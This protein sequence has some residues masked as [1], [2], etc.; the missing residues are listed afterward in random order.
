MSDFI[1]EKDSEPAREPDYFAAKKSLALVPKLKSKIEEWSQFIS[2]DRPIPEMWRRNLYYYFGNVV[3]DVDESG[4][5]RG[6][7]NGEFVKIL[8]NQARSLVRQFMTLTSKARLSFEAVAENTESGTLSDTRLANSLCAHLVKKNKIDLLAERMFE[9]AILF[10]AGYIAARWNPA[11]GPKIAATE[12]EVRFQGEIEYYTPSVE[13]VIFDE[14]VH[15]WQELDW[16]I[17][18]SVRNRHD[19]IAQHPQMRDAIMRLDSI[20]GEQSTFR[21]SEG[22]DYVAL[23]EFYH[24][25]SPSLESGRLM[26]FASNECIFFDDSNP[27]R[28]LPIVQMKPEPIFGT[29]F[30]TSVF[31]EIVPI[32]ELYDLCMS[33]AATNIAAFGVNMLAVPEGSDLSVNDIAGLNFLTYKPQQAQGGGKPESISLA[34]TA[35]EVFKFAEDLRGNMQQMTSINAAIRGEVP[36]SMSGTALAV[37]SSNALESTQSYSKA[38]H[39]AL[40]SLMTISLMIYRHFPTSEMRIPVES[41]NGQSYSKKFNGADLSSIA[42]VTIRVANPLL[43]TS[44]GRINIADNLLKAGLVKTPQSYVAVIEGAPTSIL[45]ES[46]VDQ[47]SLVK[48]E[49]DELSQGVD[50]PVLNL[51]DHAY[52]VMMHADLLKDPSIRKNGKAVKIILEHI[53]MHRN[54]AEEVD[55]VLQAMAQTGKMPQIPAPDEQQSMPPPQQSS[56]QEAV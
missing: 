52:H 16:V 37:L 31:T 4:L 42:S 20:N 30:G 45:Y 41:A 27:Y 1:D 2:S 17:I 6:G 48:S 46:E 44:A 32:Q 33:T 36:G 11:K 19:L 34:K 10:G 54:A 15:D 13:D 18:R 56:E 5:S 40:E 43:Q 24:R 8:A 28:C 39:M 49:N 14:S 25:P 22:T 53:I 21:F 29:P 38:F 47:L 7:R 3:R 55:P 12:D 35:P 26:V 50:V 51:D 9:H 23:Y